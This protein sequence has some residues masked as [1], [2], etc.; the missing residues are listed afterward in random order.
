METKNGTNTT[1]IHLKWAK[2]QIVDR[3]ICKT[4]LGIPVPT[5]HG[6]PENITEQ[7]VCAGNTNG[8]D[9]CQGDSG[10]PLV[11]IN[12]GK[13]VLSG[14]VSFGR[15]CADTNRHPG[16]YTNVAFFLDWIKQNVV[17]IF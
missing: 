16:V 13:V 10:G 5:G 2:I 14:V 1:R 11:C 6:F 4:K 9:T 7:H 8:T 15:G 17:N 12:G 3:K